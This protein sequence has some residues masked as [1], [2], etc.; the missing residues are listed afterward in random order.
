MAPDDRHQHRFSDQIKGRIAASL[1]AA[2]QRDQDV[3][4]KLRALDVLDAESLLDE[5][6]NPFELLRRL[7]NRVR[8]VR[9]NPSLLADLDLR[10]VEVLG[11]QP[12]RPMLETGS[13]HP[14]LTVVFTDLE[15]FTA[16]TREEGDAR[17]GNLLTG[18]YAA[19]DEIVAGRGGTV[20][21][22]LGDGHLTTF[23]HPRAAV[24]AS[25]ELVDASPDRLPLRAGGHRGEV[26]RIGDD[27]F[28]NVVNLASRVAD[29]ADGGQALVTVAVRD[30]ASPVPGAAFGEP[31]EARLKGIGDRVPLCE[32]LRA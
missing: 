2:L 15:G 6:V 19:V 23:P 8:E 10:A 18:H 20:V 4:R 32:V 25:L 26:V 1:T 22:R 21:K 13:S 24:L 5:E 29:A 14:G 17:A 31:Q 12:D 30:G 16:F 27:V 7:R 9:E 28:G 3:L 11:A